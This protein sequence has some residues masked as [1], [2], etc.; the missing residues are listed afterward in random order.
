MA[1]R[2]TTERLTEL[3]DAFEAQLKAE[4]SSP[5]DLVNAL[6]VIALTFQVRADEIAKDTAEHS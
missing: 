2:I 1:D 6:Q 4:S 5:A 3:G